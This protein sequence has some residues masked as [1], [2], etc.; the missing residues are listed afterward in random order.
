MVDSF[1]DGLHDM[2]IKSPQWRPAAIEAATMGH[3]KNLCKDKIAPPH[4][5]THTSNG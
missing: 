5:L 1:P 2:Q 3:E 4:P